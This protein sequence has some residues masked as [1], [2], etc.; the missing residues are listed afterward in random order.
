VADVAPLL[1]SGDIFVL[2][3]YQ[4]GLPLSL[5]EAMAASL[6]VVATAVG[7]M[8]EMLTPDIGWIVEPG[9]P[10]ALAKII[11]TVL[12]DP[13]TALKK[14][15]KGQA[16]VMRKYT[17]E[18]TVSGYETLYRKIMTKKGHYFHDNF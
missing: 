10:D 5:L 4:E 15:K 1:K 7:G 13:L 9:D 8:P 12:N 16:K 11:F 14:A 2:S 17:I 18:N 3:S 6:P